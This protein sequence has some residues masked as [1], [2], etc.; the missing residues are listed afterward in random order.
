MAKKFREELERGVALCLT[1]AE[2]SFY[3]ALA[4][5]PSAQELMKEG[6]LATM[7]RELA[8]ML[9]K[10]ATIDWQFKENVGKTSPQDQDASQAIQIPARSAGH[11]H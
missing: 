7:A 4:D 3:D 8:E 5:N 1:D 10:V 6:V 9:R 11:R 2:Q